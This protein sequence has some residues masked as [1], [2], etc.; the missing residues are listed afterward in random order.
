MY[1]EASALAEDGTNRY[2]TL[3]NGTVTNRLITK[4][5]TGD[6]IQLVSVNPNG[7]ANMIDLSGTDILTNHKIAFRY[8]TNNYAMFIDGVKVDEDLTSGTFDEGILT[9][10]SFS[11][12][13]Q[14]GQNFYGNT[15]DLRIYD[16]ALTDAQLIEL[17]TI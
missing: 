11:N 15:K 12:S 10:L 2:I 9:K 17:T 13:T 3:S 8:E 4:Y 16:K 1:W 7:G 6:A 14:T 5:G